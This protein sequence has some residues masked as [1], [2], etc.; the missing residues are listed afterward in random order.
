MDGLILEAGSAASLDGAIEGLESAGDG[1]KEQKSQHHT[2]SESNQAKLLFTL[3]QLLVIEGTNVK[4]TLNQASTLIGD[5]IGADKIDAFLYDPSIESLIAVGASD[6]PMSRRQR[7]LGLDR[8]PLANGGPEVDVFRTGNCY[9]TGAADQDPIVSLGMKNGL[10]VR[11][12]ILVPMDVAGERRG[13]LQACSAQRDAFSEDDQ[14]FLD[15]VAHW[16]GALTHR[17]ELTERI[18]QDAVVQARAVVADELI[19]VLAHDLGNY[20]TPLKGWLDIVRARAMREDRVQ[21]VE[22]LDSASRAVMRLHNLIKDLLDIGRLDQGMFHVSQQPIDLA[23]VIRE[24]AGVMGS[25]Q[26]GQLNILVSGPDELVVQ[27][28]AP[29]IRQVL[30]NLLSNALKHSPK[31]ALIEVEITSEKREDSHESGDASG[32]EEWA[33]V[34]VHDRGPGI[35]SELL[36]KL[37]TRFAAGNNSTGL[38]LGLYLARSIAEAHGGTLTVESTPG[39]GTTFCLAFPVA[40]R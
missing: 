30:E 31:G 28:D 7:Q 3:E 16:V 29:R 33:I 22:M 36:P 9:L 4:S 6:T 39:Q 12:M 32:Y 14:Y 23:A 24:T 37:F 34:K 11:S 10:G 2:I 27:A 13:V 18:A 1:L 38:G 5:A 21:D 15:A 26:T 35:S 20:I 40:P 19:T 25:M 17:A 8:V